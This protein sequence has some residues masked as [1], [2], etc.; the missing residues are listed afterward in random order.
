MFRRQCGAPTFPYQSTLYPD[1]AIGA[2]RCEVTVHE[3]ERSGKC[4]C[5]FRVDAGE[6]A[7]FLLNIRMTRRREHRHLTSNGPNGRIRVQCRL[8]WECW[9][10]ALSPDHRCLFSVI[11]YSSSI[12][13]RREKGRPGL[14]C[15]YD[16]P[17]SCGCFMCR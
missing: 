9:R 12:S 3:T 15:T 6:L 10:A 14:G 16:F 1:P 17:M 11:K 8:V 13:L 2:I 7:K 4:A 5:V